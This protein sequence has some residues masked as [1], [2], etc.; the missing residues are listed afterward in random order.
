MIQYK[1]IKQSA[2]EKC[3]GNGV[4]PNPAWVAYNEAN[5]VALSEVET[6]QWFLERDLIAPKFALGDNQEVAITFNFP[7]S[8]L[9]CNACGGRG[10]VEKTEGSARDK[11]E[12]LALVEDIIRDI[13]TG[14]DEL[15]ANEVTTH[16]RKS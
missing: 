10:W 4:W 16:E 14:D 5:P 3:N 15:E 9:S 2:C 7:D 12:L 13:E 8:E 11:Y 1:I 6:M